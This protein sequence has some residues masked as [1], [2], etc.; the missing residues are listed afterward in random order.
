MANEP[1]AP[2]GIAY[3]VPPYSGDTAISENI[4]RRKS[5][6]ESLG[7]TVYLLEH[8]EGKILHTAARLWNVRKVVAL[9][10]I[11]I[12]GTALLDKYTL[13]KLIVPHHIFVWEIHGFPEER[14][15]FSFDMQTRWVAWKNSVK[16]RYLSLL[17][18][19]SIF[20]SPHLLTYAKKKIFVKRACIIP[21]FADTGTRPRQSAPRF[22]LPRL[23]KKQV[24]IALWGGDASL[25]WQA[26]DL[27]HLVAAEVK[28]YDNNILFFLVGTHYYYPVG[29]SGNI[30]YLK[31]MPYTRFAD[32]IAQADVCLAL[33]H[34]PKH[35]PFYFCP[36]KLVDYLTAGKPVIATNIGTTS[37]LIR[38][39]GSGYLT[40]N[41]IRDITRTILRIKKNRLLSGKK[42]PTHVPVGFSQTRARSTYGK[43]FQSLMTK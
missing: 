37:A 5:A 6:L 39:A 8:R 28:K 40:D 30:V 26:T 1:H 22:L 24:F 42:A 31:N 43:F 15:E 16:R 7:H 25:P 11:R 33:Y 2:Q 36:M 4:R 3:I 12:D 18:D 20:I 14:L 38:H 13:L 17:V 35:I 29:A 32:M 41:G 19:A 27:I 21:N 10:I 23:L 9:V 34:R